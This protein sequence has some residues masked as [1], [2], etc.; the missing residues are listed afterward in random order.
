MTNVCKIREAAGLTIDQLAM[1][2]GVSSNVVRVAEGRDPNRPY[3]TSNASATLLAAALNVEVN[4]LFDPLE[5]S[6][7][8][9]PTGTKNDAT[10][11]GCVTAE[12]MCP[13]CFM[14]VRISVGCLDCE[15]K[16]SRLLAMAVA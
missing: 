7:L 4:D 3:R 6:D 16:P 5:L 2:A 15:V 9:R 14:L 1:K 12:A 11:I 8:G 13:D 10:G